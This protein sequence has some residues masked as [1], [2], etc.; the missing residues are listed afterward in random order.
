MPIGAEQRLAEFARA[1]YTRGVRA[2]CEGSW[3]SP[4]TVGD[5]IGRLIGAPAVST[6]MHQNVTVAEAGVLSCFSFAGERRRIVYLEGD[7]PAVRY[8]LQAQA[9]RGADLVA[10]PDA[11][12]LVAALDERTLLV[13]VSHVLFRT[14][15]IVDVEAIVSRA[16]A[17]GAKVILDAYQSVGAVPLDV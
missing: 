1:W 16:H 10:A 13:P 11:D 9:A 8:F 5:Q 6:V 15:E 12:A 14:G 4:V 3:E 17:V 7:F 2:W